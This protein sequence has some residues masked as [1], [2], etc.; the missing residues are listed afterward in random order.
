MERQTILFKWSM[1]LKLSLIGI[2]SMLT[3]YSWFEKFWF[4]F[5]LHDIFMIW[6]WYLALCVSADTE[7]RTNT[8]TILKIATYL[9]V[10]NVWPIAEAYNTCCSF[11]NGT[12]NE[13]PNCWD[14]SKF[15]LML[16]TG[17][18]LSFAVPR[19]YSGNTHSDHR[20]VI[21]RLYGSKSLGQKQMLLK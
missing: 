8:S 16:H 4:H 14:F 21:N 20:L 18:Q 7:Y 11:T 10:I 3:C 12:T 17:K 13:L 2:V 15:W 6:V 5:S 9:A 1:I 19:K